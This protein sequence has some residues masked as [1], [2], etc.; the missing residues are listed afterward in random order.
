MNHDISDSNYL[1]NMLCLKRFEIT[2]A[3]TAVGAT[4]RQ[5]P[6]TLHV[7]M[8]SSHYAR[9]L[10]RRAARICIQTS[11]FGGTTSARKRQ[12]WNERA[13]IPEV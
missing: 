11:A 7:S 2:Q 6:A 10:I 8:M 5:Q 3:E 13:A 1:I 12:I 4:R 9:T